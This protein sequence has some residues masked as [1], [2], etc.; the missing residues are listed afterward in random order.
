M[1]WK[2]RT[3]L[4]AMA[5]A[6]PLSA[7]TVPAHAAATPATVQTATG[8][9]TAPVQTAARRNTVYFIHGINSDCTIWNTAVKHF[10]KK[11]WTS[12]KLK[13]WGYYKGGKGCSKGKLVKGDMDTEITT[14]GRY[15]AW[16]IHDNYTKKGKTVDVVG[17]SMGG[18]VARAALTGTR[19]GTKGF[20]K[21]LSIGRVVTLGTPHKGSGFANACNLPFTPIQCKRLKPNSGFLK[22][23]SSGSNLVNKQTTFTIAGSKGDGV[24]SD[25][26]ATGMKAK[27]K[28]IYSSKN[29]GHSGYYS[30]GTS[31]KWTARTSVNYGKTWNT[32][33]HYAGPLALAV[34]RLS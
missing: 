27:Y 34:A 15:L 17:H 12:S 9:T 3:A 10:K 11:G 7:A 19:K 31:S 33:K 30:K 29:L 18:L 28:V 14:L 24:V 25:K 6:M 8:T 32:S 13:K 22:W 26:S 5:A 23:L 20:P 21:K 1:D 4:V 2:S 16:N